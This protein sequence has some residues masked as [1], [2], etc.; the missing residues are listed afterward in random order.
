MTKTKLKGLK[1]S[2]LRRSIKMPGKMPYEKYDL[3]KYFEKY[4]EVPKEVIIKEDI[5]RL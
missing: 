3:E 5:L 4:P 1:S 2:S